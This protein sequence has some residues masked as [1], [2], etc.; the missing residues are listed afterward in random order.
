MKTTLLV[1]SLFLTGAAF[2]QYGSSISSHPNPYHPPSNPAHAS[3][4]GLAAEQS[5][6]GGA[7]YTFAQGEKPAWEL[8]QEPTVSLGD[9][10][11]KLREE[12][13]KLKKARF[14]YEN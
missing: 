3:R 9:V 7:S 11:R 14:V 6:I 8:P 1:L 4:H 2:G 13:A 12:H 10:A 5:V